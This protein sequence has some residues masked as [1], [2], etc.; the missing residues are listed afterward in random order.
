VSAAAAFKRAAAWALLRSHAVAGG[1]ALWQRGT[2]IILM[3][4]RVNDAADPFFPALPAAELDRQVAF[5]SR[6]YRVEPLED[7]AAWLAAGAPGEARVALTFDDGDADTYGVVWPILRRHQVTGT[8]FLATGP[9]EAGEPLWLD[10]LRALFKSTAATHLD[11]PERGL[12]ARPLATTALRLVALQGMA[13]ALKRAAASEIEDVLG[14]LTR[15]LGAAPPP[16][17]LLWDQVRRMSAEGLRV[18]AHTHRHYVLSRLPRG[19]ARAEIAT[20]VELIE[21]AL[22]VRVRS[23][24]Y[25]NGQRGDFDDTAKQVLR[26]LHIPTA[27]TAM[28]GFARA[29]DDPLALRR[30]PTRAPTLAL[31]ACRVAGLAP[32]EP[33]ARGRRQPMTAPAP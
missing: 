22:D 24:A 30:L 32:A 23:F 3:Y 25:P 33:G 11:W 1:P 20:S 18:G 31:F 14:E 28:P 2:G 29:G 15:R 8:L 13:D 12:R 9:V 26:E 6:R 4:H 7:V 27:C 10:R 19:A 16:P 21:H 5:L 17:R